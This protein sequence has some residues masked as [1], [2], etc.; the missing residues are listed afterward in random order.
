MRGI[1][2]VYFYHQYYGLAAIYVLYLFTDRGRW[3]VVVYI[4]HT[5]T[6]IHSLPTRAQYL[7][8]CCD[9]ILSSY[10]Y[11]YLLHA[12]HVATGVVGSLSFTHPWSQFRA[13]PWL[14]AARTRPILDAVRCPE[15]GQR[16]H[17]TLH[18]SSHHFCE[19]RLDLESQLQR[20]WVST[21]SY[22]SRSTGM[23]LASDFYTSIPAAFSLRVRCWLL[24]LFQIPFQ[25]KQ[26]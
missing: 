18:K 11:A 14:T 19:N 21:E 26:W 5:L 2:F 3:L 12:S 20:W 4:A 1:R 9:T 10:Q 23:W 16:E 22:A 7:R 25:R 8:S 15:S 13:S 6:Q 24:D 17:K